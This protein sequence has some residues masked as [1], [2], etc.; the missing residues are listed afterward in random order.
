MSI[1]VPEHVSKASAGITETSIRQWFSDL[2]QN[3]RE[4]GAEEIFNDPSRIF[5]A[6]ET[7]VQL[8]RS[9]GKVIGLRGWKD[10]YSIASGPEKSSL[11]FLGTI[12]ANGRIV[13][14]LLIYPYQRVPK[15]IANS[16]PDDFYMAHSESGWMRSET[17]YEFI[18]NAFIP[19]LSDNDIT[20]PVVLFVDGHKTHL[21]LQVSVLCEEN[22]V[23][24][25]LLPPN[26]THILQPA[27]VSVFKPFKQYW[28][29]EVSN[30]IR[31]NPMS[32]VRRVDVAPLIAKV[33]KRIT[34][35]SIINGFRATGLFP[36][37][38]DAVSYS[39][40]LDVQM[41]E[42]VIAATPP[43]NDT[44]SY[45]CN[46]QDYKIALSVIEKV[47]GARLTKI[48]QEKGHVNANVLIDV[49]DKIEKKANEVAEESLVELDNIN[50]LV[51]DFESPISPEA[52]NIIIDLD[53]EAGTLP[54]ENVNETHDS[55]GERSDTRLS[56]KE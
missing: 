4:L 29:E 54:S 13:S 1:R 15:D 48:C 56:L 20:R 26:T 32:N 42:D 39:R 28:R 46:V 3:I 25:Y 55:L 18:A 6:D 21:T 24:L 50:G 49:Y 27:D 44:I 19:W 43:A 23:I 33:L 52:S 7:C 14:L 2:H 36:L 31:E 22:G 17:F 12:S 53:S 8:C 40:C 16:I 9:S 5:N 41:I 45:A 38:P 11:T 51:Q 10:I 47:L 34:P 30:F 37:N 35:A